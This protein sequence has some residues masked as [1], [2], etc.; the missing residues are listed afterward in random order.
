MDPVLIYGQN[1]IAKLQKPVKFY[2]FKNEPR[3]D[4]F[5]GGQLPSLVFSKLCITVNQALLGG[6]LQCMYMFINICG[7]TL[8]RKSITI[9]WDTF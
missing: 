3:E 7:Y 9:S 5:L 6:K 4:F 8:V 1:W 2:V